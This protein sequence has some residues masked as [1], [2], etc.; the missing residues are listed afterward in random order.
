M[1][2]GSLWNESQWNSSGGTGAPLGALEHSFH[3]SLAAFLYPNMIERERRVLFGALAT[4]V[5]YS[6]S[7]AGEQE[8]IDLGTGWTARRIPT[9]ESGGGE[10][11]RLEIVDDRVDWNMLKYV[12]KVRLRGAI[13]EEQ[14]YEVL[15]RYNA[16]KPG[17]V[18][19]I[20]MQAICN[21]DPS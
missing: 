13:D 5:L 14:T 4:C 11:W 9:I 3:A 18:Y 15:E 10:T 20:Q 21:F 8:V 1:W 19:Q 6:V 17:K 12:T 7:P 16:M 2:N